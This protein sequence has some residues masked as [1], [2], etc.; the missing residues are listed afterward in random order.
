MRDYYTLTYE[1]FVKIHDVPDESL[2]KTNEVF[3]VGLTVE[4]VE[5]HGFKKTVPFVILYG[6]F[7]VESIGFPF[8]SILVPDG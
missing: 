6:E 8:V 5:A 2:E 4:K 3:A 1:L 7:L